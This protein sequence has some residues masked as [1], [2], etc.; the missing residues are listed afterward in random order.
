MALLVIVDVASEEQGKCVQN[1]EV[2]FNAM[3]KAT[4]IRVNGKLMR[5][6]GFDKSAENLI[7]LDV[8]RTGIEI[9]FQNTNFHNLMILEA[10]HNN[11]R[12]IS[13]EIGNETYPS[14]RI[15]NF[16]NNALTI[17]EPKIF[18]HMKEVENLDL[19]YNCITSIEAQVFTELKYLKELHLHNNLVTSFGENLGHPGSVKPLKVVDI[20]NNRLK[21]FYDFGLAI[22]NLNIA[23]NEIEYLNL[24]NSNDMNLDASFNQ[25]KCLNSYN[26]ASY[27]RL[28]LSHNN[29][30][31]LRNVVLT[32]ATTVD[33]SYNKISSNYDEEE[34][35]EWGN[36]IE[37]SYI[38]HKVVNL[39][40]SFNYLQNFECI[41]NNYIVGKSL[42]LNHNSLSNVSFEDF[43]SH[44]PEIEFVSLNGNP[45]STVD[46]HEL[47]FHKD[48][49]FLPI[50]FEYDFT[51]K[52]P[53]PPR[54]LHSI[55]LTTTTTTTTENSIPSTTTTIKSEL[56]SISHESSTMPHSTS[57]SKESI[58]V[59]QS[60]RDEIKSADIE[61]DGNVSITIWIFV[62]L[63]LIIVLTIL[64]I[65]NS[66]LN[67]RNSHV[68]VVQVSNNEFENV[69]AFRV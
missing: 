4:K 60:I 26:V 61:E 57:S 65:F 39:N 54:M 28:N 7:S 25:L 10:T 36:S 11:Y 15:F 44:F 9:K 17:V 16:S 13:S 35:D 20:S 48:T 43:K 64:F 46:E 50:H 38:K 31:T 6:Y 68:R 3:K 47:K 19:S 27:K 18:K 53:S 34:D 32:K 41:A 33:L 58:S 5:F 56:K 37:K 66:F 8:S 29:I 23:K 22:E 45:L 24:Y 59:T 12:N 1:V 52:P 21:H 55:Y 69:M 42:N 67:R 63:I 30:E 62:S 40:V 14:L 49:R 51:T 2:K